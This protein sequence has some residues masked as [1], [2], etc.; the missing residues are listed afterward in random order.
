MED[1][2]HSRVGP[3]PVHRVAIVRSF[4]ELFADVGA[5][6]ERGFRDAGLPVTAL[7]DSNNYLPSHRFFRFILDTAAREGI[8]DVG[9]RVGRKFGAN[10]A[11]PMLVSYLRAA[12]TL[13]SALSVFSDLTGKTV[14][15]SRVGVERPPGADHV[16]FYHRPSCDVRHPVHAQIGWFGLVNMIGVVRVFAGADWE[17][18]EIGVMTETA[19]S[20][21]VREV[22]PNTRVRLSQPYSYVVIDEALLGLPGDRPATVSM[23]FF[24]PAQTQLPGSLE[25][26]LVAYARERRLNIGLAAELFNTSPRTLQRRLGAVGATFSE[27]VERVNFKTASKLLRERDVKVADVARALGYSDPTHFARAFRRIAGVSPSVYRQHR[28]ADSDENQ[29]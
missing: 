11:D 2:R 15:H 18:A 1:K 19:P 12:P 4:A 16:L 21:R 5:S 25:Q 22:F 10:G 8:D 23:D 17:P 14:S 27:V 13:F 20:R 28:P 29:D 3:V 26:V 9:L 6:V 7:E 24:D